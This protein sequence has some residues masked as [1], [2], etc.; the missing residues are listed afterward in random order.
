[1]LLLLPYFQLLQ[2]VTSHVG[3]EIQRIPQRSLSAGD[4]LVAPGY[5]LEVFS[6]GFTFPTALDFDD[7]GNMY[8]VESGYAYGEVWLDPRLIRIDASGNKVSIAKGSDNGPWNGVV[9]PNGSL[10]ISEGGQRHGGKILQVS[11]SGDIKTLIDDLPSVG[12]HHTNGLVIKDGYIYFGQGTATN[13]GVVGAN[14]ASFG[15]LKR[16]QQFHDIPCKD[17]VLSGENYESA[18]VLS[19][20]A[21]EEKVLTGAFSPFGTTTSPGQVIKG[22]VPCTGSVMRISLEV[23]QLV[24]LFRFG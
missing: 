1:L 7:D 21:A 22:N 12:D 16:K 24:F 18:N 20:S 17:V 13:S 4:V 15:W 2:D 6:T 23:G 3:G 19:D 14:N 5:T 10:F 9:F 11:Q 8:V